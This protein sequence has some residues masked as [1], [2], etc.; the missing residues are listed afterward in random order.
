MYIGCDAAYA[1]QAIRLKVAL[2]TCALCEQRA[3]VQYLAHLP[4]NDFGVC[5][6]RLQVEMGICIMYAVVSSREQ[7]C[8]VSKCPPTTLPCLGL[9]RAE[10]PWI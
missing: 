2:F 6:D 8:M 10:V 7:T 9:G 3:A 1:G 5:S 4:Q